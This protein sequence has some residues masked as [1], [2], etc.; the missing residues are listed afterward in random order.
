MGGIFE[1]EFPFICPTYEPK[2][3]KKEK[4][5]KTGLYNKLSLFDALSI[6]SLGTKFSNQQCYPKKQYCISC[7][8]FKTLL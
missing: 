6:T 7:K 4:R 1:S 2:R 3:G 5:K 8:L